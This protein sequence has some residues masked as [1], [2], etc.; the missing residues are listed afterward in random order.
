M[1]VRMNT[2]TNNKTEA[3]ISF[4][5]GFGPAKIKNPSKQYNPKYY[6]PGKSN[7]A[8][9]KVIEKIYKKIK[10]PIYAQWEVAEALKKKKIPV[11]YV[12]KPGKDYLGTKGVIE[13]MLKNGLNN[14]KKIIIV[15]HPDHIY[16]CKKITEKAFKEKEY[17]VT[18]LIANNS[19]VPYDS[20]SVQP[21]TRNKKA[22]IKHEKSSR[23]YAKKSGWM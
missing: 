6:Y 1:G 5:F 21:W 18:I 9:A 16:R 19:T 22:F 4:A 13:K 7:E 14:Y 17:K 15:A 3:I 23:E 12:A 20:K 10:I 2:K 8:L 11:K